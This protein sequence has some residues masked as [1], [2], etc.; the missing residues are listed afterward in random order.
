MSTFSAA[1]AVA[2][3]P[4]RGGSKGV[5]GKNIAMVGGVPLVARAVAAALAAG[6]VDVRVSTDDPAIAAAARAAGAGVITR[7]AELAGDTASSEAALLHALDVLV[8]EGV[9]PEVLVFLQAT[10]PFIEPAPLARA[11]RR[12]LDDEADSVLSAFETYAFLWREDSSG[13]AGVNHDTGFRPR[14]QDRE[15]HFQE[16][17]AFY[18]LRTAGFREAG[19]RFF[20]RIAIEQVAADRAVEIDDA[21]ELELARVLAPVF[22]PTPSALPVD[23]VVTDFDGVHTDDSALVREDGTESVLVSRSDGMGVERLRAAGIPLLILSKERNGVVAA[24]AAKLRVPVLQAVDDKAAALTE[25]LAQQGVDPARC[26][27]VGNDVN[28]LSAMAL[29][30]WPVAVADAHPAVQRAARVV[31]RRRGGH[32]AVRETAELVLAS[33]TTEREQHDG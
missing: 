5:P 24:R 10:S 19:F 2:V 32:G 16:T 18:A 4:A 27:Y 13:A 25:W 30:G 20:G 26:A 7:P 17:G 31:L 14:R 28:D 23:A 11:V 15:P 9:R 33:R 6:I 1:E 29:V 22:D 21:H 8:A 3:V 12:V